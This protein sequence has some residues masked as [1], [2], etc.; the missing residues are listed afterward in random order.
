MFV[1]R[2]LAAEAAVLAAMIIVLPAHADWVRDFN[3]GT[4]QGLIEV[5]PNFIFSVGQL[6]EFLP[7]VVN[8]SLRLKFAGLPVSIDDP[9]DDSGVMFDPGPFADTSAL[10]LIRWSANPSLAATSGSEINAGFLVRLNPDPNQFAGYVFAADDNGYLGIQKLAGLSLTSLCDTTVT[11]FDASKDWWIRAECQ[12]DGGGGLILRAREWLDGTTEP[13]TWQVEC[14]DTTGVYPPG[15]V[16]ILANEDSGG[17]GQ[18][19]DVD[20]VSVSGTMSCI[21]IC[22]NGIDDDQDG[23]TDCADSDCDLSP[24]CACHEPFADVDDDGDVD[25]D[26]FAVWQLC[27][28]AAGDPGH[29]FNSTTYCD[30][31]DREQTD[32]SRPFRRSVD[33]DNDV[34]QDDLLAFEKC[35]QASGP[36]I[37]A[38]P[39]CAD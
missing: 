3:D 10:M 26:D 23:A 29:A 25:Q 15:P 35:A 13:C 8:G 11:G 31:L 28:T 19:V 39:N 30:C 27:Y 24:P 1:P 21:E 5:D 14:V 7:T 38:D 6:D 4:A 37:L 9:Q 36:M 34:D 32:P 33:G 12:D 17:N 20:N 16:G 2:L 18:F 22:G